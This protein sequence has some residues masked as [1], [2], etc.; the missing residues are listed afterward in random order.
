MEKEKR[1]YRE[2]RDVWRRRVK[3]ENLLGG[4]QNEKKIKL[5]KF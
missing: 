1:Q 5:P 2:R 3:R 4:L